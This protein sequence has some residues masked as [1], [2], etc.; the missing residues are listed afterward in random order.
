MTAWIVLQLADS[1][2]PTGG[3]A[4][5]AGLEAMIQAGELRSAAEVEAFVVDTVWQTARGAL[6]L[7]SATHDDPA[8]L[9]E[10]DRYAGVLTWSHIAARAS[11][12]QGRALLDTAARA[13]RH[14]LLVDARDRVMRGELLGH[15]APAFGFVTRALDVTR[16]DALATY[17]HLAA[18]GVLSSAIRLGVLGPTE[19]QAVHLRLHPTLEAASVRARTSTLDDV[20]QSAPIVELVQATHDRLYSRLFQS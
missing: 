1:A 4:H 8:R 2:F 3:F 13:F 10:V 5:S 11:K 16:D 19:A 18:R 14:T 15:L 6:P 20:A 12:N 9:E 17:L 7:V